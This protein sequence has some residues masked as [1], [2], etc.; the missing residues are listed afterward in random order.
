ML[1]NIQNKDRIF[2]SVVKK[3]LFLRHNFE[4]EKDGKK[5]NSAS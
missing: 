1:I 5:E 3:K 2:Y 4:N